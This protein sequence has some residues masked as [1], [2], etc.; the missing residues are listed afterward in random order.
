[1][2]DV[3]L[4]V[5]NVGLALRPGEPRWTDAMVPAVVAL[6]ARPRVPA[7]VGIA[8]LDLV[9]AVEP[10]ETGH[11]TALVA[12]ARVRTLP[13]V[14]AGL[15]A[16]GPHGILAK[17]TVI[18]TGTNARVVSGIDGAPARPTIR[19]R[20]SQTI[21]HQDLALGSREPFGA[22]ASVTTRTR[23][24]ARTPVSARLVVRAEIQV[25][26]AEKTAPSLV[27]HA[28]PGLH[29][30]AVNA[31]RISLALITHRSFP[32]YLTSIKKTTIDKTKN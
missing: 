7:R 9:L 18:S 17:G 32:S 14:L 8:I 6:R 29:T 25:L 24:E 27:A 19:A 12:G 31:S 3:P 23:V 16:A 30:T 15:V 10:G 4:A 2:T 26:V 22:V 5:V 20:G 1:M 13:A 21:V 28:I 11:T